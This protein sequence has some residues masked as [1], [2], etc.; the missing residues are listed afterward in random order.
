MQILQQK[1][2]MVKRFCFK[3]ELMYYLKK[4]IMK[5]IKKTILITTIIVSSILSGCSKKENYTDKK[6]LKMLIIGDSLSDAYEISSSKSWT[7]ILQKKFDENSLNVSIVNSSKSGDKT[8]DAVNKNEK[9]LSER[10][11]IVI[12]NIGANDALKKI[13]INKT[14]ENYQE[15]V[16]SLSDSP[17]KPEI[18]L[19]N[20]KPP[21]AISFLAPHSKEYT[22]IVPEIASKYNLSYVPDFFNNLDTGI[23]NNKHFLTDRLHPSESAQPILANTIY[24]A[25]LP[26][27]RKKH[28][29]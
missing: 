20:I 11:D 4:A 24:E 18:I 28:A 12:M 14:I 19:V 8:I 6:E 1:E 25:V 3:T 23:T 15:I 29:Q 10:A 9:N 17:Q 7:N 21:T 26:A 2:H 13:P 27:I 5:N 16:E 22:K